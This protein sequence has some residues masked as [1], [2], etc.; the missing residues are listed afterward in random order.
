M[1]KD[2]KLLTRTT[3]AVVILWIQANESQR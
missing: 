2:T 3:H 1:S